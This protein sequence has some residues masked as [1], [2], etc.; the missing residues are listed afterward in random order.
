MKNPSNTYWIWARFDNVSTVKLNS[1]YSKVNN[2]FKGPVFKAHLTISGPIKEKSKFLLD[3]FKKLKLN[4]K[5]IEI[6]SDAYYYSKNTYM[7]FYLNV[8]KTIALVEFKNS[9]D[10]HLNLKAN[11]FNPHI[12]LYYGNQ[13]SK[14]KEILI[15]ILP[16]PV[17]KLKLSKLC[18]VNV[19]EKLNKWDI[20]DEIELI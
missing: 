12:S 9:V 18:L 17:L 20:E 15:L 5:S 11:F 3:E 16:S 6:Q 7:S 4:I 13:S 2:V 19:N 8:K 14:E 10:H 1:L